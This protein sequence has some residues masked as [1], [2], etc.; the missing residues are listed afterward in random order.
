MVD[1]PFSLKYSIDIRE[2]SIFK[3]ILQVSSLLVVPFAG[4]FDF[5]DVPSYMSIACVNDAS[6]LTVMTTSVLISAM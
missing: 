4:C 1:K 5:N 6:N 3:I 2:P